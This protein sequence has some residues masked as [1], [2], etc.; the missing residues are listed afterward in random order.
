MLGRVGGGTDG[1]VGLAARQ[2]K[3]FGADHDLER[4]FRIELGERYEIAREVLVGEIV[5]CRKPDL[6]AGVVVFAEHLEL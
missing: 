5:R 1:D 2:V 6:A 3:A 4:D